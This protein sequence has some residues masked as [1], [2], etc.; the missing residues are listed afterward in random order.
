MRFWSVLQTATNTI[1]TVQW[2][3]FLTT[4]ADSL[5]MG[6]YDGDGKQDFAVFRRSTGVWYILESSTNTGRAVTNFGAVNDFPSVGDYDGDGK[7]DLCVVRVEGT[8]RVWY[9]Q[10]SSTGQSRRISWGSATTDSLN[11]SQT[12][13]LTA[14]ASRT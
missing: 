4:T 9:I 13:M 2:G 8:E 14:T 11:F 3:N 7:T 1:R 6:D 5:A 10:N 12:L